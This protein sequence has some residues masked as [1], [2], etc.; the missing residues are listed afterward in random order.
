[1]ECLINTQVAK[2]SSEDKIK[3]CISGLVLIIIFWIIRAV[4]LDF[5]ISPVAKCALIFG[6]F[7]FSKCRKRNG[8]DFGTS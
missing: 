7:V 2:V 5:L 3:I 4:F 1:M 8:G 6:I